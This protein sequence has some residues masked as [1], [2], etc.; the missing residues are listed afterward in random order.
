MSTNGCIARPISDVGFSGVYHHWDSYPTALAAT[1]WSLYYGR[2]GGDVEVM[3]GELIDAHPAG[4]STLNDADWSLPIGWSN[5]VYTDPLAPQPARCYCHGDRSEDPNPIE[6]IGGDAS[7]WRGLRWAYVLH[8]Q[9]IDVLRQA[10]SRFE[11]RAF[12]PW[13]APE[14]D[15]QATED[16]KVVALEIT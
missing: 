3:T 1:L 6:V 9:G 10:G 13:T 5:A 2:Y 12:I 15:W 4:W 14:P 8:P 7:G 11:H 16:G